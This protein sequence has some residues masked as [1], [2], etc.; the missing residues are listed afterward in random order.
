MPIA[1][2]ETWEPLKTFLA[3]FCFTIWARGYQIRLE[4]SR[5]IEVISRPNQ[6]GTGQR[7]FFDEPKIVNMYYVG[8]VVIPQITSVPNTEDPHMDVFERFAETNEDPRQ[9]WRTPPLWGC[10]DSAPYLHDGRA[11]TLEESIKQHDGEAKRVRANFRRLSKDEQKD[12]L[13]FLA[14]LRAPAKQ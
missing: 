2:C 12:L 13:T 7:S 1:T 11:A 5:E 3:T 4:A 14:C 9:E 10:A 6:E 8:T